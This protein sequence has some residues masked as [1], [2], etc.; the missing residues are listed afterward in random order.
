MLLASSVAAATAVVGFDLF[1]SNSAATIAPGQRVTFGA[2]KGSAAAGDS[3]IRLMAGNTHIATLFN[4]DTGFP[5]GT[6]MFPVAY[7]HVGPTTRIYATVV[8]APATNP[9]NISVVREG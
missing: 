3:E 7:R 5:T 8:A 2:V 4:S 1:Q 9:I 6:D